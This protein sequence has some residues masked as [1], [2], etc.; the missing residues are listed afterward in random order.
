MYLTMTN[1]ESFKRPMVSLSITPGSWRPCRQRTGYVAQHA[2]TGPYTVRVAVKGFDGST[3]YHYGPWKMYDAERFARSMGRG[4]NAVA[5]ACDPYWYCAAW[6]RVPAYAV[7]EYEDVPN[8]GVVA[9]TAHVIVTD[10]DS[11]YY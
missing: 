4:N 6:G 10:L 3:L 2:V 7:H 8:W 5:E 1:S 11:D 9:T